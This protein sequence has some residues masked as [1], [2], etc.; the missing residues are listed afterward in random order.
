MANA[1]IIQVSVDSHPDLYRALRG[2]GNNFGI[3][4][5]FDVDT[6][7]QGPVWGGLHIWSYTEDVRSA[8]NKAFV[9]FAHAA[10]L[11]PYVSLFVGLGYRA[12][13]YTYGAGL[14]NARGTAFPPVFRAF[15]T[16]ESFKTAN[17]MSTARVTTMSNLAEELDQ[18]DPPGMRRRFTTATFKADTEL[19]RL[20]IQ[21][22]TEEVAEALEEG[23]REDV[24]FTPTIGFQPLSVNLLQQSRKRGGNVLGLDAED[25]P[26]MSEYKCIS[27]VLLSKLF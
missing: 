27:L 11:D 16:E 15:E 24:R 5:R 20:I 4:T 12:G 1:S 17:I 7:A 26:F 9:D 14:Y 6:Y 19:Q 3:V 21:I 8:L 10:A 23:L 25:A 13:N 2:G 22:F 18:A